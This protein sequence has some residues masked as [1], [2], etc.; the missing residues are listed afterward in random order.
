[1]IT[2]TL[3]TFYF[4]YAG[5]KVKIAKLKWLPKVEEPFWLKEKQRYIRKNRKDI[6]RGIRKRLQEIE[7][8]KARKRERERE[9]ELVENK[10]SK[11]RAK[12]E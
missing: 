11:K 10:S 7:E 1:V 6:R 8:K 5:D 3:L 12:I 4:R 2:I 9:K